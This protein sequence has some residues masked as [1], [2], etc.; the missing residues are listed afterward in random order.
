MLRRTKIQDTVSLGMMRATPLLLTAHAV[1]VALLMGLTG[2]VYSFVALSGVDERTGRTISASQSRQR[3]R[4]TS[5]NPLQELASSASDYESPTNSF[6]DF[7]VE[8]LN[9]GTVVSLLHRLSVLRGDC[10]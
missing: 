8:D 10:E 6:N 1:S 2:E 9:D 3:F 5:F 4:A 7:K